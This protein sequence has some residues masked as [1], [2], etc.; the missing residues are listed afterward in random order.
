[1]PP[2]CTICAHPERAAIDRALVAGESMRG[3]ARRF[4]ASADALGRHAAG[5]LPLL[6]TRSHEAGE[7][8][9]AVDLTAEL[10]R[11]L[12]RANL[13]G[14]AC[15]AWLR[16]PD[17][18]GRYCIDP[19]AEEIWVVVSEVGAGGKP[20]RRRERLAAVIER[21]AAGGVVID[22]GETRTSDPRE[23]VL[24]T[25]A[26]ARELLEFVARRREV[27]ELEAR[28]A[29]LEEAEAARGKEGGGAWGRRA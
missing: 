28:L 18:P 19:R 1:M 20:A 5:H 13:L 14:D 21:L 27:D 26:A 17:E 12:R 29:A 3:V 15:D 16:H 25:I 11:L 22:R 9:R 23:L 6:L 24:K 8:D 2:R 7:G 4:A 10:A